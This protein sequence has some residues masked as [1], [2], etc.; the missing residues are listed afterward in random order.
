MS[1]P[2]VRGAAQGAWRVGLVDERALHEA[3]R[4]LDA[5]VALDIG[6]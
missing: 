2:P 1:E 5:E 3:G 4:G 6:E